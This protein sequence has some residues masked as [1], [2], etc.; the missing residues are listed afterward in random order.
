[1]LKIFLISFSPEPPKDE[2]PQPPQRT[3]KEILYN[4][5]PDS[6][7]TEVLVRTK[8]EADENIAKERQELC[9]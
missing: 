9:R 8:I 5:L 6:L 1:V 2:V 7:K 3:K 4:Q